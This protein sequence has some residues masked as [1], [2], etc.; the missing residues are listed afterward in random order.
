MKGGGWPW[1]YCLIYLERLRASTTIPKP[2]R[3]YKGKCLA[4]PWH[5][6]FGIDNPTRLEAAQESTQ[7][8]RPKDPPNGADHRFYTYYSPIW[9]T[10]TIAYAQGPRRRR[11]LNEKR[12]TY[13][14]PLWPS[15]SHKNESHL[16]LNSVHE[17]K[18]ATARARRNV[19]AVALDSSNSQA[20]GSCMRFV[21][22]CA[23]GMTLFSLSFSL[24]G[25]GDG[26]LNFDNQ[27][28][29]GRVQFFI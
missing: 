7:L 9:E 29:E 10:T 24:H 5:E 2:H 18:S 1:R 11:W 21:D 26:S 8:M 6:S 17:P 16:L 20:H 27:L 12:P 25:I 23:K 22:K 15:D 14:R 4:V 19:S 13:N 28:S 3:S